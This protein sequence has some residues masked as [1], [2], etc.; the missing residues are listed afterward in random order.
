MS[1]A[2]AAELI[3]HRRF[4]RMLARKN[5]RMKP[6]NVRKVRMVTLGGRH[7]L[8]ININGKNGSRSLRQLTGKVSHAGPNFQNDV[9]RLNLSSVSDGGKEGLI[10]HEILTEVTPWP[11]TGGSKN[12]CDFFAMHQGT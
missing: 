3:Q 6:M 1:F 4:D 10:D 2:E 12:G 7:K 8:A 5:I 11:K 9:V